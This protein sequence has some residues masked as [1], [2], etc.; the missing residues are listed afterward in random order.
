[1]SV[2]GHQDFWLAGSRFYFQRED[3][4]SVE[5][6]LI[7]LGVIQPVNPALEI[8]SVE[9][10]DSDGGLK[11]VV[12]TGVTKISESMDIVCSNM[13]LQN[14][15]YLFLASSPSAFTQAQAE[16]DIDQF[17]THDALKKI[18]DVNGAF[19]F[20]LDA[21]AGVYTGVVETKTIESITV[22]TKII[23]LTGDQTA[24]AGLAAGKSIIVNKLGLANITNSRSYTVVSAILNAGKTD[25]TV[26]EAPAANEVAIT[27]TLTI[28]NGGTIFEQDTDWSVYSLARGIVRFIPGGA[29]TT[30]VA[31][32]IIY[33]T[34]AL[35]GNRLINPQ[36]LAGVIKG[37]GFI[38]WGRGNNAYQSVR[39]ATVTIE[40]N[41]AT[42][43]VDEF[44]N[45]TLT[46]KVISDITET[47]PAGRLLQYVGDLPTAD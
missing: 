17:T 25:V 16:A 19:V 40:P 6:P 4:D 12:D 8:E 41:A 28:E 2:V 21:I 7:D 29:I 36:S 1:M 38:V 47:V 20:G 5:Q 42:I 46:V 37:T 32:H 44:S 9:L 26:E 34:S 39:E 35:S 22:S 43:G 23:K 27:G 3:Q 11:R 45:M 10:E 33:T 30:D 31:R 13:N 24:E 15:S 14:L 18:V